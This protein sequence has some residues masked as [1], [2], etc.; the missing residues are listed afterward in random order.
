MG[1]RVN[2]QEGDRFGYLTVIREVEPNITP[3]GTVQRKFLCRCDCGY[4]VIHSLVAFRRSSNCSCGCKN[5]DIGSLNR[6]YTKEQTS[7]FLY[8]T[9]QGMKQRCIDPNSSHYRRYGGRGITICEEWLND[10]SKFYEWAMANG[11]SKELTLDRIDTNGNYEPSN[12]RWI[13]PQMQAN[14]KTNNRIIYFN[15]EALTMADF[16]RKYNFNYKKFSQR[17]SRGATVEEA[18]SL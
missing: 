10:Y 15:N 1:K 18:M 14:N 17:L 5:Y 6:K 7:S 2:I 16:C 9:W 3:C 8:S 4:E 13:S 12:C 11:A